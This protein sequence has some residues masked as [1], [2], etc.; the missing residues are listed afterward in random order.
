MQIVVKFSPVEEGLS[1]LALAPDIIV[2]VQVV[3]IPMPWI[4]LYNTTTYEDS[5]Y[6]SCN[7]SE[8]WK[9]IISICS[10]KNV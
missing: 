2:E 4:N 7:G 1:S 9:E 3:A 10:M 6:G 5:S 8:S